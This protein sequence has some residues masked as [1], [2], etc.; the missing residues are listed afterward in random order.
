MFGKWFNGHF[1]H[2][3]VCMPQVFIEIAFPLIVQKVS[4]SLYHKVILRIKNRKTF[5]FYSMLSLANIKSCSKNSFLWPNEQFVF[6]SIKDLKY[7]I[8]T[9]VSIHLI[10]WS[11]VKVGFGCRAMI[12]LQ[13][14][15]IN[16]S[17]RYFTVNIVE[18][19][20]KPIHL[21]L[22]VVFDSEP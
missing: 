12:G 2:R 7:Q 1:H 3:L 17:F 13:K 6:V 20:R 18:E 10:A 16:E 5:L 4:D 8:S 11:N 15:S 19:P 21:L 22:L 9:F 14:L